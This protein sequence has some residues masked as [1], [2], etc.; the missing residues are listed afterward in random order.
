M[1]N[2]LCIG[3]TGTLGY[4]VVSTLSKY[5]VTN[6]DFKPHELARHNIIL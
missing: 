4:S 1:K 6:A 5:H 3:G 2:I